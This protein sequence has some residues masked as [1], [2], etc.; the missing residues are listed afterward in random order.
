[1]SYIATAAHGRTKGTKYE[2]M[3]VS[4]DECRHATD[5]SGNQILPRDVSGILLVGNTQDRHSYL[6]NETL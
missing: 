1:M 5:R 4:H 6:G 2:V 3:D